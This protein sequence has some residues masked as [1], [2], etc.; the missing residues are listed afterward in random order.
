M[1]AK[2]ILL[3]L[4]VFAALAVFGQ[5]AAETFTLRGK[6]LNSQDKKPVAGAVV[7][8]ASVTEPVETD[9]NGEFSLTAATSDR[10]LTVRYSGFY[11]VEYT[12]DQRRELVI[13]LL[14]DNTPGYHSEIRLPFGV[15]KTEE[16]T[17]N[18]AQLVAKDMGEGRAYGDDV[19][20]GKFAGVRTLQK[21]GMPGEG[22]YVNYRGIRSLYGSNTPLLMVDGMPVVSNTTPSSVFTGYSRNI[23]SFVSRNELEQISVSSGYD[24]ALLGA[25][26]S[27]GV[28]VMNTEHATDLDTRVEFE[29]VNSLSFLGRK[30]PL[31]KGADYR[32]YLDQV[33]QTTFPGDVISN[34][35]PFLNGNETLGENYWNYQHNTDWQEEIFKTAFSTSNLLKVKGG[36]N[37]AKYAIMAGYTHEQGIEDNTNLNRYFARFNGDMVMSR[38]LTMFTNVGFSHY[39]NTIFEQ[40]MV[41]EINPML[42][43]LLNPAIMGPRRSNME[44]KPIDVWM[45]YQSIIRVSNPA[46][47]TEE[48][49]SDNFAYN[50]MINMGMRY[51]LT[52]K[53]DLEALIGINYD[54]NREKLFVP[55]RSVTAV[56]PTYYGVYAGYNAIRLGVGQDMSYYGNLKAG[57][58]D[59]WQG[60]HY[61]DVTGGLQ[62]LMNKKK[63]EMGKGFNTA[64]D[65]NRSLENVANAAG[66]FLDGYDDQWRWSSVFAR[67]DYNFRKQFYAGAALS[68]DASSVAGDRS[69][70]F[71]LNP[72]VNA[73]WKMHNAPFLRDV[74]FVSDLTLR[75]EWSKKHNAHFPPMLGKFY[76]EA[77]YFKEMGGIVRANIPNEKLTPE[78]VSTFNAGVD[79]STLGRK[80][81][82]SLDYYHNTTTDLILPENLADA[83]GSKVRYVNSGKLKGSGFGIS[84]D[85]TLLTT[86]DFQWRMGANIAS[87]KSE[88]VSL[89]GFEQS[90]M[91]LTDGAEIITRKGESPYLFYGYKAD[92]VYATTA[93][94][95]SA[96]LTDYTGA[97][98]RGGDMRYANVNGSDQV[99]DERDKTVIGDPTPDFYGGFS[100]SFRYGQFTLD[101][102]FTYSCGNDVYNAVRRETEGMSTFASQ[103]EAVKN[104][105]TYEGQHTGVP[106]ADLNDPMGNSRFSSR[107][108]EDGSFLKLKYLTLNYTHPEK[109]FV[110]NSVQAYFTAEN[111]F[112]VTR[113]LGY[114]PEFAYSYDQQFLGLDYGKVPGARMFKIGLR[115]GF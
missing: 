60:K 42:A 45:P 61:L 9:A 109:W 95:Q 15:R 50:M 7:S 79:F 55:G 49:R 70:L 72:A 52:P 93:E 76:Y 5:E 69:E 14:P 67:A 68:V 8:T 94:A 41:R 113:Y 77:S 64:T 114:D 107:W 89:G 40:G 28:I 57:Y 30:I 83:F 110:F 48:F 104:R 84:V 17:G 71:L 47:L 90:I 10:V 101:A 85:A 23:F 20:T 112:T 31:L 59:S 103:T 34:L 32:E 81:N 44:G 100:S 105:W 3:I 63:Y 92:G 27:N 111:L 16:K 21:S 22:N 18:S 108:I 65:Y 74:A 73:G 12:L 82:I 35:F 54:Y 115:L 38:R 39:D 6:V 62:I 98:F 96:G 1:K 102:Q 78:A 56:V 4:G 33:A 88:V 36:D 99:I 2:S 80:L 25:V 29:T 13:Y 43:A 86:G 91:P 51:L 58:T 66:K 46:F 53:I 106:R 26:G 37:I 87:D 11:P 24:A 97:A 19:L 75:A